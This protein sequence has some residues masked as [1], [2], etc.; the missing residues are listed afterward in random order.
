MR[1]NDIEYVQMIALYKN[2]S[3]AAFMLHISQPALS[4]S[5][6][7]LEMELGCKLFDR[8]KNDLQLTK[9]GELFVQEGKKILEI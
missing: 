7:K 4:Q 3:R 6:Q 2:F 5:V 8:R 1:I 9:E